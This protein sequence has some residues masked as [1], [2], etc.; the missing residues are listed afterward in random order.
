MVDALMPSLV[1][2]F[3][4]FHTFPPFGPNFSLPNTYSMTEYL[5]NKMNPPSV[6]LC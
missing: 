6:F 1:S 4:T 2:A 5:K 3:T